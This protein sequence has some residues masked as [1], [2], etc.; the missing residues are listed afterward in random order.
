[1]VP[2][3]HAPLPIAMLA[4]GEALALLVAAEALRSYAGTPY[5]APLRR[6]L[7]KLSDLLDAPIT[8]DLGA[9]PLAFPARAYRGRHPR[10]GGVC[11]GLRRGGVGAHC[12]IAPRPGEV[13][14]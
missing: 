12:G 2:D 4:E 1:M 8:L 6:A 11:R 3:G 7:E 13:L 9:L 14:G 10:G 5:E